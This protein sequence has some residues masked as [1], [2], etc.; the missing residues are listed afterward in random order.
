M[1][2]NRSK[3]RQDCF[4]EIRFVL[5]SFRTK[6]ENCQTVPKYGLNNLIDVLQ[7]N[8]KLNWYRIET[9]LSYLYSYRV[10]TMFAMT[11]RNYI[12]ENDFIDNT[13]ISYINDS[14]DLES[15]IKTII[16]KYNFKLKNQSL[17]IE[18][19]NNNIL[20]QI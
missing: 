11:V 8:K 20:N 15:K 12:I 10:D 5:I 19:N 2:N 6:Y 3:D 7:Y 16:E 17:N 4:N 9:F 14:K 1:G 13:Y 18:E